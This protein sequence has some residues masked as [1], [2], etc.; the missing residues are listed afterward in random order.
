MEETKFGAKLDPGIQEKTPYYWE[1]GSFPIV[2]Q[3]VQK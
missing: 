3:F 2:C 1:I